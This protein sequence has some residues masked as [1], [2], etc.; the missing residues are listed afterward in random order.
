MLRATLVG[1]L[2][3]SALGAVAHTAAAATVYD[4]TTTYANTENT[5][6]AAGEVESR[7]HGNEVTL[8]GT[9][10]AVTSITTVIRIYGAGVAT[11]DI[12][13]RFYRNDGPD[14]QPGTLLWESALIHRL[15][16]SGAPFQYT[17]DVPSVLVPDTFTW[18]VQISNRQGNMARM[19]P[20]EYNP[21]TVGSAPFGFW[22]LNESEMWE[23]TGLDEPPFGARTLA[24]A[25]P[26]AVDDAA[27]LG[28][29]AHHRLT[30][31]PNPVSTGATFFY[32]AA[33]VS[34]ALEIYN[35]QG[36]LVALLPLRSQAIS[37]AP[38]PGAPRGV[39]MARVAGGGTPDTVKFIVLR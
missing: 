31:H 16:D 20:S 30:V 13:F 28:V 38:L 2:A 29:A 37:W 7:Q 17:F 5:L 18:T 6:L 23:Y 8:A 22:R 12:R 33:E 9:E 3:L 25:T 35:P 36:R 21:P 1:L 24:E 15:I 10:R 32:P 19:G 4:N 27:V 11:F 34:R 26:V 39:Y 14:G